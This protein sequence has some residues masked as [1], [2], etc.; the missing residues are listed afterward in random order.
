MAF[1]SKKKIDPCWFH[2]WKCGAREKTVKRMANAAT[3][4]EKCRQLPLPLGTS[5]VLNF[6]MRRS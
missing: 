4:C 5:D 2:C 6:L 1:R 3:L